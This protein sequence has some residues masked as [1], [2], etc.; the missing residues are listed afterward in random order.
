[1][2]IEKKDAVQKDALK[3]WIDSGKKGTCEIATGVGKTFLALHALCTMPKDTNHIFLAES[4]SREKDLMDDIAKYNKIFGKDIFKEY[5]LSFACYQSAYKWTNEKFG[6]VIADEIH[7]SLTPAYSKF[8]ENN[9]YDA[10]IGLSATVNRETEY[11]EFTKG[12]LIDRI[13]PVCY[14]YSLS[15]SQSE[16]TSRSIKLFVITHTLDKGKKTIVAGNKKKRFYQTEFDAY[17][18][19]DKEHKKSWYIED[20]ELRNLK[21]RITSHKRSN[22]LYKLPS[23]VPIVRKLLDTVKGKTIVFGNSLDALHQVTPNVM[24]S[25]LSKKQNERIRDDFDQ[26][27]L[28]TIGSFKKLKQGANLNMLDNCII[29]S[30]YSTEK[31]IIQ[32]IGRLRQNGK[33]GY[34]FVILTMNTQE[35]VW[36]KKMTENLTEIDAIYCPSVE[37]CLDK[38]KQYY[39]DSL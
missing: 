13:A 37:Y 38:Y 31:D 6:L 1:M 27:R 8:Y 5:N 30:Y 25:R 18:Y 14:T 7:D 10:I 20:E 12:E 32:R 23:K 21:I 33:L 22:I 16:G 11:E 19:W 3:H 28:R 9:E 35:E 39:E 36:F 15:T 4:V 2:L 34:V 29:M 24:S 17:S 26:N